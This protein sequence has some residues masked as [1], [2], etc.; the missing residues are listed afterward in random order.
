MVDVS[1]CLTGILY[2]LLF[3]GDTPKITFYYRVV[4]SSAREL[5]NV[6][7]LLRLLPKSVGDIRHV[8]FGSESVIQPGSAQCPLC[9]RSNHLS[10]IQAL[11]S[12]LHMMAAGYTFVY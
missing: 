11:G 7:Q 4:I 2:R 9:D 10:G 3:Q 6:C 1:E 12:D 5:A 8:R